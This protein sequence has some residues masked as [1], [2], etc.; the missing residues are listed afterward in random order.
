MLDHSVGYMPKAWLHP[1]ERR[2]ENSYVRKG[3]AELISYLVLIL[4]LPCSPVGTEE[5]LSTCS[6]VFLKDFL[7][8]AGYALAMDASFSLV[9]KKWIQIPI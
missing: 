5:T 2:R 4:D 3:P 9:V 7:P 6:P 8:I 1:Q